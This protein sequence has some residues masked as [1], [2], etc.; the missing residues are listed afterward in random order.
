M[1]TA[2]EAAGALLAS[3]RTL[4]AG[5]SDAWVDG[6]DDAMAVVTGIAVPTL[7]GVWVGGDIVDASTVSGLLDEV[8]AT[9]LPHCLGARPGVV[10]ELSATALV[11][12]MVRQAQDTP[13]MVLDPAGTADLPMAGAEGLS[14]RILSPEEVPLHWEVAAA[15]FGEPLEAFRL[16]TPPAIL[17]MDGVR[18]YVGELEGRPVVTGLGVTIGSSVAVFNIATLDGHR[19]RGFGAA[20]TARAVAD[21]LEHGARWAWLQSSDAGYGV[22]ER[23][24]FRTVER[25]ATWLAPAGDVSPPGRP[26]ER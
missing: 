22:Y 9:G 2:G 23:L 3:W 17:G 12:G 19:R 10:P 6:D 8:A 21:G 4:A 18:C 15:G 11:R 7:N 5:V 24:G 16:M 1:I 20:V 14:L 26:S 25:W 13:L